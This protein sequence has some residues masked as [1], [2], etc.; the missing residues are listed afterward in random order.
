VKSK[1]LNIIFN[2]RTVFLGHKI[3]EEV[4]LSD[5]QDIIKYVLEKVKASGVLKD[6]VEK[7]AF[8]IFNDWKTCVIYENDGSG[9]VFY[10]L[11]H[12]KLLTPKSIKLFVEIKLPDEK[13]VYVVK[14]N[15]IDDGGNVNIL[16]PDGFAW[17]EWCDSIYSDYDENENFIIGTSQGKKVKNLNGNI[18]IDIPYPSIEKQDN[19]YVCG[20][21]N[22]KTIYDINGKVIAK[23]VNANSFYHEIVSWAEPVG[24]QESKIFR[25]SHEYEYKSKDVF[26]FFN[27]SGYSF[28]DSSMN[29]II[30]GIDSYEIANEYSVDY[31]Y[32]YSIVLK[33]NDENIN[34]IGSNCEVKMKTWGK[35][36]FKEL[37]YFAVELNG[38]YNIYSPLL[39]KFKFDEWVDDIKIDENFKIRVIAVKLN[40]K[41][42]FIE[43]TGFSGRSFILKEWADDLKKYKYVFVVNY[44]DDLYFVT[45][46]GHLIPFT[47]E[48][49]TTDDSF[50]YFLMYDDH[51]DYM[52]S[53]FGALTSRFPSPKRIDSA[54]DV[55][56]LLPL[57][58]YGDSFNYIDLD[59]FLCIFPI[60]NNIEDAE[61][62]EFKDNNV[63]ILN[64]VV[65][66]EK[67]KFKHKIGSYEAP[68]EIE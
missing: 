32:L 18:I 10:S 62:A 2:M 40:N 16:T 52:N 42:N 26:V 13:Y 22:T 68:V 31:G 4:N 36:Y 35:E 19:F 67:H 61:M 51:V 38:K 37:Y 11:K 56:S 25:Q 59:T 9:C 49:E 46:F 27:N 23:D 3:F 1:K 66:G 44:D 20:N 21:V 58:K 50:A 63:A 41:Y 12:D 29:F 34:F 24:E 39:G 54:Y 57:I 55:T 14:E 7:N 64:V 33:G 43:L 45:T 48:I 65:G 5:E 17:D 53:L 60:D 8:V 30:D 47:P 15:G 28:F 6:P